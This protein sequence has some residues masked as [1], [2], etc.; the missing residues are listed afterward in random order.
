MVK[1]RVVDGDREREED[2]RMR[3]CGREVGRDEGW[4]GGREREGGREGER[5]RIR[6]YERE[7]G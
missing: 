2:R 6:G 4:A 7:R 3:A 1:E 5:E